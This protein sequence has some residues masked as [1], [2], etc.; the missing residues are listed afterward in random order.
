LAF[1]TTYRCR[2]S[3]FHLPQ[4]LPGRQSKPRPAARPAVRYTMRQ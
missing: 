3:S 2:H 4:L 1:Q